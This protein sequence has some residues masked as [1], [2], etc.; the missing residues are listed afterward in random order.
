MCAALTPLHMMMRLASA[1]LYGCDLNADDKRCFLPPTS[2]RV[3]DVAAVAAVAATVAAAAATVVDFALPLELGGMRAKACV[4][5][6]AQRGTRINDD[7]ARDARRPAVAAS[8]ERAKKR[9]VIEGNGGGDDGGDGG[10]DVGGGGTTWRAPPVAAPYSARARCF[11]AS[12][13]FAAASY[14]FSLARSF[15]DVALDY[16]PSVAT[17]S[18]TTRVAATVAAVVDVACGAA[19][20]F[21]WLRFSPSFCA[22]VYSRRFVVAVTPCRASSRLVASRRARQPSAHKHRSLRARS[23]RVIC[24]MLADGPAA[25]CL[26]SNAWLVGWLCK[27]VFCCR[28]KK[29][30]KQLLARSQFPKKNVYTTKCV[31]QILLTTSDRASL[32]EETAS[33]ASAAGSST[34]RAAAQIPSASARLS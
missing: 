31:V 18:R 19:Q 7:E 26:S 15:V 6:R 5:A 4:R 8:G 11:S 29:A 32:S 16:T 24:A 27:I 9:L 22:R 20:E 14:P 21:A 10:G 28:K 30:S 17:T 12:R 34:R 13:R 33:P 2:E 1:R 25:G 23:T 3:V